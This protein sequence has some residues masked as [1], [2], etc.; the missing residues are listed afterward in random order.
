MLFSPTRNV[1]AVWRSYLEGTVQ[2]SQSRL[3]VCD[4]YKSQVS[5]PAKTV[6]LYKEQQLKKVSKCADGG[7]WP[8]IPEVIF[9]TVCSIGSMLPHSLFNNLRVFQF[10]FTD[11]RSVEWHSGRA[12]GVGKGAGQSQEKIL[13]L[14]AGCPRYT[15]EGRHRSQVSSPRGCAHVCVGGDVCRNENML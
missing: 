11:H 15:R 3:N 2:V 10:P 7:S 8:S 6:R 9:I 13:R 4:N 14:R 5:D 12:A 1:Y